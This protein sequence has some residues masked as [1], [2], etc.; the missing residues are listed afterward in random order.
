[1]IRR[2]PAHKPAPVAQI[3]VA[4]RRG[5]H[6]STVCRACKPGGEL[7]EA[8]LSPDRIDLNHPATQAFL[9]AG[10][11]TEAAAEPEPSVVLDDDSLLTFEQAARAKGVSVAQVL[12]DL[13]QLRP[14]LVPLYHLNA[15]EFAHLAG[16]EVDEVLEAARGELEPAVTPSRRLDLSHAASL[17]F[18]SARP[19][20]RKRNGDPDA[21]EGFLAP[22]CVGDDEID[23]NHPFA[24]AYFAR[25]DGRVATEAEIDAMSRGA[26]Q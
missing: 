13:E 17:G 11:T 8:L 16:C 5:C 3:D 20:A 23:L 6:R 18:M 1:M 26:A 24:Q 22:A 2:R 9:R 19:F 4:N 21:P 7:F 12:A 15:E 25:L 14:A 10:G